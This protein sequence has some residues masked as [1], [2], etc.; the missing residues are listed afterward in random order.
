MFFFHVMIMPSKIYAYNKINVH[1]IYSL[2]KDAW[3]VSLY[4]I[5]SAYHSIAILSIVKHLTT[6]CILIYLYTVKYAVATNRFLTKDAHK[7]YSCIKGYF[8]FIFEF[9][10]SQKSNCIIYLF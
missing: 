4:P 6:L 7:L 9:L 1:N 10:N 5:D 2:F 3:E 8:F